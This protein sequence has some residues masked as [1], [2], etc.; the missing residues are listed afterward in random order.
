VRCTDIV[1]Q[2]SKGFDVRYVNFPLSS[3]CIHYY[4]ASVIRVVPG[5]NQHVNLPASAANFSGNTRIRGN[6]EIGGNL[7]GHQASDHSLIVFPAL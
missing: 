1:H 7:V 5:I 3:L 4:S 2:S 6:A